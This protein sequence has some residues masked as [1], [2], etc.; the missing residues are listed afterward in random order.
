[1][2]GNFFE[3]IDDC[4]VAI[5]LNQ[6]DI[7]MNSQSLMKLYNRR[8]RVFLRLGDLI[9]AGESFKHVISISSNL[10]LSTNEEKRDAEKQ[11][12]LLSSIQLSLTSIRQLAKI[13]KRPNVFVEST[14]I[15][16]LSNEVL[17]TCTH[18][19]EVQIA[20]IE[21]MLQLGKF[22]ET[23]TFI[24]EVVLSSSSS[25]LGLTLF[26]SL[27]Y[28]DIT[29]HKLPLS[30]FSW[31]EGPIKPNTK[32]FVDIILH[33]G[34]EL[35]KYY[36][37]S[38]K[39]MPICRYNSAAVIDAVVTMVNHLFNHISNFNTNH[40]IET[41]PYVRYHHYC[42]S[43]NVLNSVS[44]WLRWI[45]EER[46]QQDELVSFKNEGD[47]A[48]RLNRFKE[49]IQQYTQ[50]LDVDDDAIVW[51]A[52]LYSNRAAAHMALR[53]YSKAIQDC[54]KAIALD[55]H[56]MKAYL[57]RAR[58]YK[59]SSDYDKSLQ[60]YEMYLSYS[61]PSRYI[62]RDLADVQEERR[63]LVR[64]LQEQKTSKS[65]FGY[66][67][68]GFNCNDEEDS[69]EEIFYQPKNH[70]NYGKK[71]YSNPY[72]NS[73]FQGFQQQNSQSQG[74]RSGAYANFKGFNQQSSSS[75]FQVPPKIDEN[76]PYNILKVS[77]N[78][79]ERDIKIAYRKLALQFHPDK[80]KEKGAEDMF[81]KITSAYAILSDKVSLIFHIDD[82]SNI[83]VIL[84]FQ[85][86][87]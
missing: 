87:I 11:I 67:T 39:N 20:K 58:A 30:S 65:R 36:I 56:Y 84:E 72:T 32:V 24:E 78:A 47:D 60:D 19:R 35:A 79:T 74:W 64:Q 82:N 51:N 33:M 9:K 38:L 3:A 15:L 4:D 75:R 73:R 31:A 77:L 76:D 27:S 80:N 52:I 57:R 21:A 34:H 70:N 10:Q 25:M 44:Q 42:S 17:Q 22:Q 59:E 55:G 7:I 14:R 45:S 2:L 8:G 69:D 12:Q 43:S 68:K 83:H 61:Y 54:N 13:I 29:I 50:A 53:D 23:K 81:K 49:A 16:Q 37:R 1:M 63:D 46:S 62:P 28:R 18:F 41:S 26:P 66:T 71:N 40:S 5:N 48:F 6:C 85:T 86:T